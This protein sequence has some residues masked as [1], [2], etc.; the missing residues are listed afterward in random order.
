MKVETE[1]ILISYSNNVKVFP[2]L[3]R[4][5]SYFAGSRTY[6]VMSLMFTRCPAKETLR[7]AFFTSKE[8]EE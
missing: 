8:Y 4:S 5:I 7:E 6:P 2:A 3:L 1:K